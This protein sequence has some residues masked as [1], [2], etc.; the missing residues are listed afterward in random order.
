MITVISV[1]DL[2]PGEVRTFQHDWSD[3]V[4]SPSTVDGVTV[5]ATDLLTGLD[6]T[7]DVIV[8]TD[9]TGSITTVTLQK[10][11]GKG[12]TSYD[13]KLQMVRTDGETYI[14]HYLVTAD[15]DKTIYGLV[16]R[17]LRLLGVRNI[18]TRLSP[19]EQE[20]GLE[21][22]NTMLLSWS[23]ERMLVQSTVVDVFPTVAGTS[24]YTIG[25]G[26]NIDTVRPEQI[27]SGYIVSN[28]VSF[29]LAPLGPEGFDAIQYK[30]TTMV[31]NS[32]FYDNAAPMAT[33]TLSPIP[34]AIYTVSLRSI[35]EMT[36]YSTVA[37]NHGLEGDYENAV[38]YNLAIHLA[39]KYG[40]N[41]APEVVAIAA[42]SASRLINERF[43]KLDATLDAGLLVS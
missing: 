31:P 1:F 32:F 27:L 37:I 6:G 20:Q 22:L 39:P 5:T 23:S 4:V 18:G 34:D 24:A 8:A 35:K 19:E 21:G 12:S 25:P 28:S 26:G 13:L 10:L 38:S 43:G 3:N 14:D 16:D 36:N 11:V 17:A 9:Q 40:M 41:A 30:D 42:Q 7:S 33:V 2:E 15:I 29:P